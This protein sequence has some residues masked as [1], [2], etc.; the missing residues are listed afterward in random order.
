MFRQSIIQNFMQLIAFYN[1]FIKKNKKNR[2]SL[3]IDL[4][5]SLAYC[6]FVVYK[7]LS[8]GSF[9]NLNLIL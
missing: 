4:I 6:T 7:L 3:E 9:V 8:G 2:S 5:D 1:Y